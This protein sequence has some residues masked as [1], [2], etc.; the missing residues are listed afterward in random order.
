MPEILL[1]YEER[2]RCR[3]NIVYVSSKTRAQTY[4]GNQSLSQI[5]NSLLKR[6]ECVFRVS[7]TICS[8]QAEEYSF[9]KNTQKRRIQTKIWMV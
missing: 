2:R 8:I 1:S 6:V 5:T 3:K 9:E 4:Y 7:N